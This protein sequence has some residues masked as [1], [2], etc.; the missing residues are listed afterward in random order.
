MKAAQIHQ[1]GGDSAVRVNEIAEPSLEPGT[2]I[3]EI[4][5]AGVNPFDWKLRAGK[6][7]VE[8]AFPA[9]MGGDFS[10]IVKAAASSVSAFRTGDAIYGQTHV[11]TGGTGSFAEIARAKIGTVALK[12]KNITHEEAA[13]LPLVG[14]SAWQALVDHI[15]LKSGQKIFI[16]GGAGGIGA[17][18]IQ[19]AKHLGAY[20]ATSATGPDIAYVRELGADAVIDYKSEKFEEKL[21]HDFDAVYDTVGGET[22]V[23][24]FDLLKPNGIIVSMLEKPNEE[25]MQAHAV[26]AIGQFTHITTE[27]L[28]HIRE[29]VERGKLNVHIDATFPLTEADAALAH[30]AAGR[31]RGKIVLTVK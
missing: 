14:S 24:S 4:H 11:L 27:R 30:L 13:A 12:P 21:P 25:L 7:G 8:L 29:L 19:I 23:R 15:Q 22:Y 1:F 18:A 3:A 20:V 17:I 6:T 26:T 10:G 9:T 31:V 28:D 5:A 16:H 2:I